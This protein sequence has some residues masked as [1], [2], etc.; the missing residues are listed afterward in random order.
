MSREDRK[1]RK[2]FEAR[3][4]RELRLARKHATKLDNRTQR[5]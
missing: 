4:K 1:L 5:A 3:A 2:H